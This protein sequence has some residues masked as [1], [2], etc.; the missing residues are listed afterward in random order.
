M[1]LNEEEKRMV[2]QIESTNQNAGRRSWQGMTLWRWNG[3]T[4]IPGT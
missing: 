3:L 2:Y 1:K 4:R